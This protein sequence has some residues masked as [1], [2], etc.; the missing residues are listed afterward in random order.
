MSTHR[1]SG[2]LLLCVAIAVLSA[3]PA[4]WCGEGTLYS[5]DPEVLDSGGG[6]ATSANYVTKV[7]I[8]QGAVGKSESVGSIS[9]LGFIS[10]GGGCNAGTP[11]ERASAAGSFALFRGYP[12]PFRGRT[13]IRYA[14][15]PGG[16]LV[17][18]SI[19]NVRGQKVRTLTRGVETAG[20]HQA[21]WDGSDG[22]G[23]QVAS[24]I[25]YCVMK[26]SDFTSREPI[27][28]LR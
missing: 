6:T 10:A 27:V 14:T 8:A 17:D 20:N 25:Y 3:T 23:R 26:A 11:S 12:N 7:S 28:L 15:P 13:I 24:G 2:G 4:L 16:V 22:E 19:Y 5:S 18:L 21:C 1:I 9:Y